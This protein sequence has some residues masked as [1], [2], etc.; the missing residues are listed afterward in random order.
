MVEIPLNTVRDKSEK[1]SN[2]LLYIIIVTSG[3]YSVNLQGARSTSDEG[4]HVHNTMREPTSPTSA[5]DTIVDNGQAVTNQD[6][7][8]TNDT[9]TIGNFFS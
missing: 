6:M 7:E 5:A 8:S 3:H 4:I 1:S 2:T 9:S